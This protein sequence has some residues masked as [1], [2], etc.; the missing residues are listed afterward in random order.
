VRIIRA[1]IRGFMGIDEAEMQLGKINV[2][3]GPNGSGKSSA[4]EGMLLPIFGTTPRQ[5]KKKEWYNMIRPPH[6]NSQI[7]VQVEDK[8]SGQPMVHELEA[9]INPKSNAVSPLRQA[10]LCDQILLDPLSFFDL[11]AKVKADLTG[12]IRIDPKILKARLEERGIREPVLT[13]V[14]DMVLQYRLSGAE[15]ALEASR[16]DATRAVQDPGEPPV[17]AREGM[18]P[19]AAALEEVRVRAKEW[20]TNWATQQRLIEELINSRKEADRRAGLQQAA[21]EALKQDPVSDTFRC[22]TE[23]DLV[24]R[25]I[26]ADRVKLEDLTKKMMGLE[27]VPCPTCGQLY[28]LDTRKVSDAINEARTALAT[29]E[30][31]EAK[32]I[33]ERNAWEQRRVQQSW[34]KTQ[35]AQLNSLP[36]IDSESE[37][38]A[39]LLKLRTDQETAR[40][41]R[42]A[43]FDWASAISNHLTS[44]RFW[45]ERKDR[46]QLMTGVREQ[47][48]VAVK[49]IRDPAFKSGLAE[50]PM[51]RVRTRL[52]TT[53]SYF[54]MNVVVTNELE[55]SV[56]TRPWWLLSQ[57]QKLEASIMLADA[58]AYI[59]GSKILKIDGVDMLVNGHQRRLVDFLRAV[60]GDYD[61]ILLAL[62]VDAVKPRA[63]TYLE[64]LKEAG[65][66]TEPFA[67]WFWV[68]RNEQGL[69]TVTLRQVF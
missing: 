47:W 58:F 69:M 41:N 53:A 20:E 22:V 52:Q 16:L 11:P 28:N 15:K 44:L 24:T 59:G 50:D 68:N 46:A 26:M 56:N 55:V 31:E 57:A 30:G 17:F 64:E 48:D 6:R 19:G 2:F 3:F 42:D 21:E 7:F 49:T 40:Q 14:V 33:Q 37:Y 61:T 67:S 32:L 29:D 54:D 43:C 18:R 66:L 51:E 35:L 1:S 36:T 65:K 10:E 34:A 62:A 63:Y 5:D 13:K 9:R 25:K 12:D 45:Q 4:I 60:Q 23:L 27:K 38:Q 39:K 8:S